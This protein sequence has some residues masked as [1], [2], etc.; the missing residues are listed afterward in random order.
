MGHL[1]YARGSRGF[2]KAIPGLQQCWRTQSIN[3]GDA[4]TKEKAYDRIVDHIEG[5]RL[6]IPYVRSKIGTSK[7]PAST[8]L[9]YTMIVPIVS[10]FR[11]LVAL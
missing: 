10:N 8:I 4:S 9:V 3:E 6:Y 2:R 7:K 1:V 11:T 5:K